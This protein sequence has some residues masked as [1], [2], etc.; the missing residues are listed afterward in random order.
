VIRTYSALI[1]T[2]NLP[3]LFENDAA[4]E[5]HLEG[6]EPCMQRGMRRM[7]LLVVTD[8]PVARRE[9]EMDRFVALQDGREVEK[10]LP[11]PEGREH[12]P[13]AYELDRAE[14]INKRLRAEVDR[15]RGTLGI[16]AEHEPSWP[17]DFLR[18][19]TALEAPKGDDMSTPDR[20]NAI[21]WCQCGQPWIPAVGLYGT[22]EE[23]E[24]PAC[25]LR[26]MLAEERAKAMQARDE[27]ARLRDALGVVLSSAHPHPVEHPTMTKAWAHARRVAGI[28]MEKD[29][30]PKKGTT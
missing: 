28:H 14:A 1:G 29:E 13:I 12:L 8:E 2:T 21:H 16:L 10:P 4:L 18:A 23:T 19:R 11:R 17:D 26:R 9:T 25:I 20:T 7:T 3:W 27:I 22:T 6:V 5:A 24:C 30:R 15:L